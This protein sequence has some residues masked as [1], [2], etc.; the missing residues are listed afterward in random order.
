MKETDD[1][2]E[3]DVGDQQ[4]VKTVAT[5][6][7]TQKNFKWPKEPEFFKLVVAAALIDC[8]TFFD[9]NEFK[10][11]RYFALA[12]VI[13]DKLVVA[14]DDITGRT[15]AQEWKVQYP[16]PPECTKWS[17]MFEQLSNDVSENTQRAKGRLQDIGKKFS[18][19]LIDDAT[20]NDKKE[21]AAAKSTGNNGS[22]Q[23]QYGK[24]LQTISLKHKD[25]LEKEAG[26]DDAKSKEQQKKKDRQVGS[27]QLRNQAEQKMAKRIGEGSIVFQKSGDNMATNIGASKDEDDDD[28]DKDDNNEDEDKLRRASS[29]STLRPAASAATSADTSRSTTRST[30]RKPRTTLTDLVGNGQSQVEIARIK[31]ESEQKQVN[32]LIERDQKRLEF[33]A[34]Q[35]A[36]E[37]KAAADQQAAMIQMMQASQQSMIASQQ[38]MIAL[39]TQIAQQQSK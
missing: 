23:N 37:R 30:P 25:F 28:D 16:S 34:Q 26:L 14:L 22:E 35:R 6:T 9:A 19:S 17:L 32:A 31:A 11:T 7:A 33:E 8:S 27:Q 12:K 3:E 38:S 5:K 15:Q 20:A 21:L 18:T 2:V 1:V 29:S 13:K 10:N 24:F 39:I 36:L 4:V